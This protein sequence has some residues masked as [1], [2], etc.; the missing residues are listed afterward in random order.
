[1]LAAAFIWAAAGCFNPI[2][3]IPEEDG[4]PADGPSADVPSANGST[5]IGWE[6]FTV[7]LRVGEGS[8]AV[9]GPDA[10]GIELGGIRNT[11]QVIAVDAEGGIADFQQ[12][13]RKKDSDPGVSFMMRN[14][15]AGKKYH[16][17]ILMGHKER[18]YGEAPGDDIIYKTGAPTL[19][20]AGFLGDQTIPEGG[21]I[22]AITMKPLVVDTAFTYGGAAAQAV[23][24]GTEL[25]AGVEAS[26]DHNRGRAG[27]VGGRAGQDRP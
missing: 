8:R 11:V 21:M 23:P 7:T 9:A 10:G 15:W 4:L 26:L 6:E 13:S 25:P 20:A 12:V 14:L 16:F 2:I 27:H 5:G 3:Y 18:T 17:L 1:V 19:L 24:G 22:L